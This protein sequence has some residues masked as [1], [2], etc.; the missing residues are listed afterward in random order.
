[1]HACKQI[2]LSPNNC[3]YIG[4]AERDIIAGKAAGMTTI[5]A[6]FGYIEDVE[7][8]KQWE[9]HHY[10]H[11]VDEILPWYEIWLQTSR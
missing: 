10:I 6:L 8:A 7:S 4:D 5:G 9:A 3:I 11:H 1:L 2:K